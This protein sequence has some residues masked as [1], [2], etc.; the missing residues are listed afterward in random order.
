MD[1][2]RATIAAVL[3]APP[4]PKID[5]PSFWQRRGKT[6]A[7]TALSA[8][9]LVISAVLIAFDPGTSAMSAAA[10]SLCAVVFGVASVVERA[11]SQEGA[12]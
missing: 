6:L 4:S 11:P 12:R 2:S 8:V 1:R 3:P 7:F 10:A 5:P 9:A